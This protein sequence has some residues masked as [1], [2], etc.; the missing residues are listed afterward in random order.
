MI[1]NFWAWAAIGR[2][3]RRQSIGAQDEGGGGTSAADERATDPTELVDTCFFVLQS[4]LRRAARSCDG[5]LCENGVR[6]AASLLRKVLLA[7]LTKRL[8][9]S[10]SSK[11]AGAAIASAQGALASAADTAVGGAAMAVATAKGTT[12]SL[13]GRAGQSQVGLLRALSALQLC[14]GYTPRLW[15]QAADDFG[16]SLPPPAL[17]PLRAA[18]KDAGSGLAAFEAALDGGIR[19]L[20]SSLMPRLRPR[21]EAFGSSSHVL[22][23]EAAFGAAEAD[24]FTPYLVGELE[25]VLRSLSPALA[26]G[27]RDVLLGAL[28]CLCAERLEALVLAKQFDQFGALQ[29][30][31]DVRAL[32][33]RLAD[34]SQR[35]VRE[36]LARLG[37]MSALLNLEREAEAVELWT[38]A[39]WR[40]SPDEAKQVLNLRVEFREDRIVALNLR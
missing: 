15:A 9:L 21:L 35:P 13:A 17:A 22:Q 34:L 4:S 10:L 36:H 38:A 37:Q 25:A 19:E 16:R 24:S 26:E 27:A 31:R 5:A 40:L 8:K 28:V 18:L 12:Q 6:N 39:G 7:S 2:A 11:L 20:A 1:S 3:V 23:T 29:F 14:T 33:R 30:D 32:G